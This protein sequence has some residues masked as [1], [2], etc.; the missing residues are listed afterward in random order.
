MALS[1]RH[2]AGDFRR[3]DLSRASALYLASLCLVL[4]LG[5]DGDR[6]IQGV[7]EWLLGVV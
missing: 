1:V 2:K 7:G 6:G 4:G 5:V 3:S